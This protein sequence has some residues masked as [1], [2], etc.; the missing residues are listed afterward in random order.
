MEANKHRQRE[1][2]SQVMNVK[3]YEVETRQMVFHDEY[4]IGMRTDVERFA[5]E[6][7]I[8]DKVR[9]KLRSKELNEP[10]ISETAQ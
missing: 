10:W 8:G 7:K 4:N 1:S 2:I 5:N 9:V 6:L 3:A